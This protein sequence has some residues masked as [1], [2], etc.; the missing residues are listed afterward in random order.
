MQLTLN[1]DLAVWI[2][3]VRG[4]QSRQ[5][6]ITRVL[7]QQMVIQQYTS[8]TKEPHEENITYGVAQPLS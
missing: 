5:A 4:Q 3:S 6:F 8:H 7:R 2:D 1:T